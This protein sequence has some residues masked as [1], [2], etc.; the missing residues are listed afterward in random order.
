[1]KETEETAT[2]WQGDGTSIFDPVLCEIIYSWFNVPEGNVLDVFAGGSVRGIVASKLGM[3]YV[4]IDLRE[5]QIKANR[6]NAIEVLAPEGIQPVWHSGDSINVNTIAKGYECDLF[7]SCPPYGDLEVYSD[8]ENDISNMEYDDFLKAYKQIITNGLKHLKNDRF[9]VF[10]VGDIRDKKG[11]YRNLVSDTIMA[12]WNNGVILYNE[13]I[14][15]NM[16]G[17]LAIRAGKQFN[18][19]RKVGKQHQNVLVFYKGNPKNIKQHFK[20]LD[21]SSIETEEI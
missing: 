17:S 12:F 11:F 21:F 6:D 20:P 19:G 13:I 7:F 1:M 8:L 3:Q 16:V 14:L 10:V 18:S 2:A 4:G 9:A 15:V 5:E